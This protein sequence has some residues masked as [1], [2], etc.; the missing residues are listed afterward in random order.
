M[1]T[2]ETACSVCYCKDWTNYVVMIRPTST[3]LGVWFPSTADGHWTLP[4]RN[5]ADHFHVRC[6]PRPV[7]AFTPC[8]SGASLNITPLFTDW[9][10]TST[11]RVRIPR[12]LLCHAVSHVN[13]HFL[14]RAHK[15]NALGKGIF[16][17]VA[18]LLIP[19]RKLLGNEFQCNF[20]MTIRTKILSR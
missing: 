8:F 7:Q 9:A 19:F 6:T 18:S 2:S 16:C 5:Q 3:S 17:L 11:S 14:L 15:M 4:S 13:T 1:W 20:A 10:A 12:E